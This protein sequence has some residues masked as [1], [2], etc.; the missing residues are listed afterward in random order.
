[1]KP[2]SPRVEIRDTGTAKGRGVFTLEAMAEG[3]IV[4]ICPVIIFEMPFADLPAVIQTLVFDWSVLANRPGTHALAL[5]YGG[6]Y[7]DDNPANM[8]YEAI[9]SESLLQLS[10]VRHIRPGE[11]LTIN[12]SAR[13]GGAVWHDD[14]WFDRMNVKPVRS[15]P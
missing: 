7:N 5:G 14:N 10:A 15:A 6:L 1:M 3:D 13:G 4:E 2:L 11:E 12:Y 9:A 8:R